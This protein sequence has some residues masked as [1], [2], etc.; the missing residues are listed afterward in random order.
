MVTYHNPLR[1]HFIHKISHSLKNIKSIAIINSSIHLISSNYIP[2]NPI[3]HNTISFRLTSA[4][5]IPSD[6]SIVLSQYFPL[7]SIISP[8]LTQLI[9]PL[10]TSSYSFPSHST[11]ALFSIPF[12]RT[13]SYLMPFH[14]I[15]PCLYLQVIYAVGPWYVIYFIFVIF[16]GPFYL[17]NLILAVVAASYENEIQA[18]KKVQEATLFSLNASK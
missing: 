14:L 17:I 13:S 5:L 11:F 3:S 9:L 8:Q 2:S 1:K 6:L 12:Y 7:H 4:P 18:L 10:L 16:V 15:S